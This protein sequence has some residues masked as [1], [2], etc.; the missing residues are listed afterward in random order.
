M[1]RVAALA[2]AMLAACTAPRVADAPAPA[3]PVAQAP[4]P[5]P[6]AA[7]GLP[8][9]PIQIPGPPARFQGVT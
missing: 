2:L 1:R 5:R 6:P 8:P 4:A 3:A 9:A 7:A